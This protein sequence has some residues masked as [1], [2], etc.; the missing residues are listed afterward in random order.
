[1]HNPT[2]L[3]QFSAAPTYFG[4][5]PLF[6]PTGTS[7]NAASRSNRAFYGAQADLGTEYLKQQGANQRLQ[8]IAPLFLALMGGSA[9]PTTQ[10]PFGVNPQKLANDAWRGD[11]RAKAMAAGMTPY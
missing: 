9:Q 10:P 7:A 8:A 5:I 1:M 6:R 3:A 11:Q 4:G 2:Y